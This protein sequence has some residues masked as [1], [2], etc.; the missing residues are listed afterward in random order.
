MLAPKV[1]LV[2]DTV[3]ISTC[4]PLFRFSYFLSESSVLTPK[5]PRP[6][7][8]EEWRPIIATM[9][10]L[11]RTYLWRPIL[12]RVTLSQDTMRTLLPIV[13]LSDQLHDT[14]QLGCMIMATA[15]IS[16]NT[17]PN[18]TTM[19]RGIRCKAKTPSPYM[20]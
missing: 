7:F 5:H 20:P 13:T 6:P 2:H 19:T 15:K 16:L 12:I 9:Q 14:V 17:C 10:N 3:P 8:H 1:P 11:A 4:L 18:L